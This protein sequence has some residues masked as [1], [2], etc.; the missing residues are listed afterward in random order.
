MFEQI[1]VLVHEGFPED[2]QRRH[3][4]I[5]TEVPVQVKPTQGSPPE[6]VGPSTWVKPM[7]TNKAIL[8]TLSNTF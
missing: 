3:L 2:L 1:A 4:K 7:F 5:A 6:N 8:S